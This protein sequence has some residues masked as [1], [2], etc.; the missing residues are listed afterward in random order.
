MA[1]EQ[2]FDQRNCVFQKLRF[3]L[4][5]FFDENNVTKLVADMALCEEI[6]A[7][8]C[9]YFAVFCQPVNQQKPCS[10]IFKHVP[11]RVSK[12]NLTKSLIE[13]LTNQPVSYKWRKD[14]N[15]IIQNLVSKLKD[16]GPQSHYSGQLSRRFIILYGTM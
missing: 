8:G 4:G 9:H 3:S 13:T 10:S 2:E 6:I 5:I 16:R 11:S 15:L 12:S 1:R 7:T 14:R